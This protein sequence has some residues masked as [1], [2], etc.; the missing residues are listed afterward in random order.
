MNTGCLQVATRELASETLQTEERLNFEQFFFG[1]GLT[2]T[3]DCGSEAPYSLSSVHF[4]VTHLFSQG[5]H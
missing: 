4:H 3:V 2:P 5:E 1:S